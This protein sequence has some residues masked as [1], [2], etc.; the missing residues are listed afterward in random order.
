MSKNNRKPAKGQAIN[1]TINRE[2]AT[3]LAK[4]MKESLASLGYAIGQQQ[5][6]T[7]LGKMMGFT[8][9]NALL[10][11]LGPMRSKSEGSTEPTP[12]APPAKSTICL[13]LITHDQGVNATVHATYQEARAE[14][15]NYAREQWG[16]RD[17]DPEKMNDED[18]VDTFFHENEEDFL[19]IETLELPPGV[20][21]S[22]STS[23]SDQTV[24][25]GIL[26]QHDGVTFFSAPTYD[27]MKQ[28]I[29]DHVIAEW[30]QTHPGEDL[31][32]ADGNRVII[33]KEGRTDDEFDA[34][35]AFCDRTGSW[36]NS[37]TIDVSLPTAT[38]R[39]ALRR[40]LPI[41]VCAN[42]H[43]AYRI[44]EADE[45]IP[46]GYTFLTSGL[47]LTKTDIDW[48]DAIELFVFDTEAEA[49][50]MAL[51][52]AHFQDD[53]REGTALG[54]KL[55]D[56]AEIGV[57]AVAVKDTDLNHVQIFDKRRS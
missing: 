10:A 38:P 13:A 41:R 46:D 6:Y 47:D 14:A 5:A 30:L 49:H 48:V 23:S 37:D 22:G 33:S 18:V 53:D 24:A 51:G 52:I 8:S 50:A 3:T 1:L 45:P 12:A 36:W 32:D 4:S 57:C 2:R 16:D 42:A 19:D 40:Q 35:E 34:L 7:V 17:G 29:T 43:C 56:G 9:S 55:P 39:R 21:P 44:L 25:V 54:I 11:H 31:T 27:A 28:K 15:A 20:F 26:S